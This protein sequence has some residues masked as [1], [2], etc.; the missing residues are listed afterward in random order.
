MCA[1]VNVKC[2]KREVFVSLN[3]SIKYSVNPL[4]TCW[5]LLPWEL[6]L[7]LGSVLSWVALTSHGSLNL[8]WKEG[9]QVLQHFPEA[10]VGHGER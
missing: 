4:K 1:D 8:L 7:P 10:S 5:S 3:T 9:F 2:S 6:K